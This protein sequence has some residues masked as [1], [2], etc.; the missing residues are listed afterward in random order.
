MWS[1]SKNYCV[2]MRSS[3]P[4]RRESSVLNIFWIARSSR[5]MTK[6][7]FL[8]KLYVMFYWLKTV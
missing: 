7:E 1:V 3:F 5:A 4:R 8:D 2:S 6:S